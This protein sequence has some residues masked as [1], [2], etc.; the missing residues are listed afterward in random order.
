LITF[1]LGFF[2]QSDSQKKKYRLTKWN[3]VCQ[4]KDQGWLGIHNL[5]IQ[6]QC[7]LSK[8]L[9]KLI[10]EEGLWQ[11]ILQKKYLSRYTIGKVERKSGDSHF[12]SR[13]MKAKEAFPRHKSFILEN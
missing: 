7:I 4:P 11:T 2:W 3:I 1:N 10:N 12:W 6:N 9:F 8:W 13:L 5:E